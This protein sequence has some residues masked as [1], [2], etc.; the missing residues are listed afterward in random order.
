[1][2]DLFVCLIKNATYQE[3]HKGMNCLLK[4]LLPIITSAESHISTWETRAATQSDTQK[5]NLIK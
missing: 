1:M 2:L 4:K 5:R 3:E